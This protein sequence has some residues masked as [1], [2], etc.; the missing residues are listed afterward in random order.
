M[1]SG[2]DTPGDRSARLAAGTPSHL[3]TGQLHAGQNLLR[4][5]TIAIA[6]DD[7]I[8][9]ATMFPKTTG[10]NRLRHDHARRLNDMRKDIIRDN[11]N[12]SVNPS[13]IFVT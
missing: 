5:R 8:A 11:H 12:A 3:T 2:G 7:R 4:D 1:G 10:T 6:N 9:V 13:T